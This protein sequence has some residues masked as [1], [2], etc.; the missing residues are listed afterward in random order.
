MSGK[1]YFADGSRKEAYKEDSTKGKALMNPISYKG[2]VLTQVW[3]DSRLLASLAVWMERN[4]N[5]PRFLSEIVRRPLVVLAETLIDGGE[6]EMIEDTVKAR[7]M[8]E[9][10]F[11][12]T[13]NKG[14]RGERNVLHNQILSERRKELGERIGN[15]RQRPN[16]VARPSSSESVKWIP[17]EEYPDYSYIQGDIEGRDRMIVQLKMK[18]VKSISELK[19]EQIEAGMRS[20]LIVKEDENE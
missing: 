4:G 19:A 15:S 18:G 20:G 12:I 16:D 10:R 5:Y 13:L 6:M 3:I 1:D 9:N 17:I 7:D 8:L 2:D 11:R 14:G